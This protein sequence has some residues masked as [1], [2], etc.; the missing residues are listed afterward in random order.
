MKDYF[1]LLRFLRP[2]LG[3][4]ILASIFMILSAL[5]DGVSLG[6]IVPLT[7]KIMTNKP[8]IVPA[9]LPSFLSN[10]IA[11]INSTPQMVLLKWMIIAVFMLFLIKGIVSFIQSYLMS[12][13]GQKVVRDIRLMLYQK[14]QNL[15]LE[16]FT[17]CTKNESIN[18]FNILIIKCTRTLNI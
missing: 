16:Y 11:S 8:I 13:I 14:M 2:H 7:D 6:M 10:F 5:F 9:K 3:Q 12:D 15:S 18:Y 17:F 1:R 4:F